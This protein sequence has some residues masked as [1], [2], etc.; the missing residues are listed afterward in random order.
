MRHPSRILPILALLAGACDD[1]DT[2][3][4]PRA[5]SELDVVRA[6]LDIYQS[7]EVALEDGYEQLTECMEQ[8]PDGGMG[9]HF[10]KREYFSDGVRKDRPEMLLYEPQTDGSLQLVAVEYYVPFRGWSD[11]R[12]PSLFGREFTAHGDLEA[13]ILHVWLWKENPAGTFEDWNPDVSCAAADDGQPS[14]GHSH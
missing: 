7:I 8:A 12:A 4:A 11:T 3:T 9:F 10:V 6:Q 1:G 13:Y 5:D 14:P 2:S